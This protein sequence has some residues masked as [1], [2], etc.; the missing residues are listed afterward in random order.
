MEFSEEGFE[1]LVK[2]DGYLINPQV[3]GMVNGRVAFFIGGHVIAAI[4]S[5]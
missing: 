1:S 4:A 3:K 2:D 5:G